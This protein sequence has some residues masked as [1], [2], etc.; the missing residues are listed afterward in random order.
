MVQQY[1]RIQQECHLVSDLVLNA[2]HVKVLVDD[3]RE[4]G[5]PGDTAWDPFSFPVT[6]I[7]SCHRGNRQ[8]KKPNDR[9]DL[10]ISGA[11]S[12]SPGRTGTQTITS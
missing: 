6:N 12:L 8:K 9:L 2:H 4:R 5:A 7:R 10:C 3:S 1:K 11:L